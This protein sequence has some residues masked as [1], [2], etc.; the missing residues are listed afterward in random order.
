MGYAF[1][2]PT[3]VTYGQLGKPLIQLLC[4]M[5]THVTEQGQCFFTSS[6]LCKECCGSVVC[7]L[8]VQ[9]YAHAWHV[10]R[11][12]YEGHWHCHQ[13]LADPGRRHPLWNHS[14]RSPVVL[15]W[16][17]RVCIV[18]SEALS[19][20]GCCIKIVP[21]GFRLAIAWSMCFAVGCLLSYSHALLFPCSVILCRF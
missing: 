12:F 10:L 9:Q 14:T 13:A 4:A 3:L 17:R 18:C 8:P 16:W 11:A 19:L 6:S 5:G 21:G 15:T 20:G 7:V 1:A 2:P